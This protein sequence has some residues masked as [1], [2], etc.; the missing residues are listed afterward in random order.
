M[1]VAQNQISLPAKQIAAEV[2]ANNWLRWGKEMG[3]ESRGNKSHQKKDKSHQE[4]DKSFQEKDKSHQVKDKSH[5]EKE[6]L[7]FILPRLSGL[8]SN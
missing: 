4:K 3:H 2:V 7:T 6:N 5:Q 1:F 8:P